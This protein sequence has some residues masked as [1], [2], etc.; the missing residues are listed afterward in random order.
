[1]S[2]SCTTLHYQGGQILILLIQPFP[3]VTN[4]ALLVLVQSCSQHTSKNIRAMLSQQVPRQLRHIIEQLHKYNNEKAQFTIE[5]SDL[6]KLVTNRH[7]KK[8]LWSLKNIYI[9]W[10]THCISWQWRRNNS[11]EHGRCV[12]KGH[13]KLR[14]CYSSK[15]KPAPRKE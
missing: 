11:T 15:H 5:H 8:H 9:F 14:K 4:L 1:M 2:T 6:Q 12:P 13:T 7:S 10:L 3:N